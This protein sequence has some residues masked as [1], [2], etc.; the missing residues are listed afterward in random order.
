MRTRRKEMLNSCERLAELAGKGLDTAR[1]VCR[2]AGLTGSG[3][4][5][6]LA[7]HLGVKKAGAALRELRVKA[8]DLVFGNGADA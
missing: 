7:Q 5:S 2:T 1:W 3:R 8:L 6:D 4:L